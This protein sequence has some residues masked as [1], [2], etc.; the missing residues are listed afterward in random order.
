MGTHNNC[1]KFN[2]DGKTKPL[3]SIRRKS[4]PQSIAA[5][6]SLSRLVTINF[7]RQLTVQL[8]LRTKMTIS[9][10]NSVVALSVRRKRWGMLKADPSLL[11]E[12]G[13]HCFCR[14]V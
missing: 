4:T 8:A 2:Y 3:L 10:F 9:G 6:C 7:I 13:Q 1:T 14:A 12:G 5:A 11:W